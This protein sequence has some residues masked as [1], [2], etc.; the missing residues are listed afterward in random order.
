MPSSAWQNELDGLRLREKAEGS[1]ETIGQ[2]KAELKSRIRNQSA[3]NPTDSTLK[4]QGAK[5]EVEYG[6]TD[7][8]KGAKRGV[9]TGVAE[10]QKKEVQALDGMKASV[11]LTLD[12]LDKTL[13]DKA[14]ISLESIKLP[15][16]HAPAEAAFAFGCGVGGGMLLLTVPRYFRRFNIVDDVPASYFKNATRLRGKVVSITDGD[17]L[18][19]VMLNLPV[20]FP[21][22][23]LLF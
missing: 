13:V 16:V 19:M 12:W 8:L 7:I 22:M 15:T 11:N 14:G 9:E 2:R 6:T 3:I 17:T 5:R 4:I 18:R 10:V 21:L 23:R 20:I 1:S